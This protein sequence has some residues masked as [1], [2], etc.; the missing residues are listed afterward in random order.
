MSKIPVVLVDDHALVRLGL[1]TLIN[2]EADMEVISEAGTAQ[3]ALRAVER[4]HP[5]VVLMDIRLPGE[6]G[7]EVTRQIVERFPEIKVVML[8]S[9]ADEEL[10]MSAIR[11]GA[12]G[13]SVMDAATTSRLFARVRAAE[14]KE[15]EDAFRDLTEREMA[16]LFEVGQGKTNA[17]IAQSLNLS[18][19]TARNYVSTILEKLQLSNRIELA[20]YS[21]KYHLSERMKRE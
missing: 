4:F 7:L 18:E 15:E 2:D 3:E 16:V 13:N 9:F 8:T 1:K 14:R 21:V 19:K 11:A 5:Q 12:Q 20:T 17:E 6:G 10:V